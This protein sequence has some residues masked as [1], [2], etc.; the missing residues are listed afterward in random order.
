MVASATSWPRVL[1]VGN[2]AADRQHSMERYASLLL[3]GLK[4]RLE[5]VDLMAPRSR[6]P[7]PAG[8]AGKWIGY[9]EKYVLFGLELA[10]RSRRYDVVHLCDHGNALYLWF[11][12]RGRTVITCH[13]CIAIRTA[14]GEIEAPATRASGRMAQRL[15]LDRLRAARHVVCVSEATRADLARL[16]DRSPASIAVI[17]NML[18]PRPVS[19]AVGAG[20]AKVAAP[21]FVHVGSDVWYKN[22]GGVLELFAALIRHDRFRGHRL[23]LI[24]HPPGAHVLALADRLG[25][26]DRLIVTGE[27]SEAELQAHYRA[28]VALLFPSLLEGFGWP[29]IEAQAAA[30]P[31][32]TS[33]LEPMR[34]VAGD[35][36]ILIDP[37]DPTAAAQAVVDGLE[38][39]DALVAA[40][41]RNVERFA[42]GPIIDSIVAFYRL[43]A[44]AAP[45]RSTG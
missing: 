25:V 24:G 13:D 4:D 1:L 37:R 16:T 26:G 38:D 11:L 27:V 35:G 17:P 22:R 6:L 42:A 36:A 20:A 33:D 12:P 40:G 43:M 14:L 8:E 39:R 19:G 45:R 28:A 23:V 7:R 3:Q 2:Y 31:V 21:Y 32:V 34:W 30:C 15:I 10:W 18:P 44:P 9:L 41:K 5:T 29:I